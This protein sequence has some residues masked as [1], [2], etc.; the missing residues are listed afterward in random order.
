METIIQLRRPD[1][2]KPLALNLIL[3]FSQQFCGIATIT[4]YAVT[5][6]SDAGTAFDKYTAT[7]IFGLVRLVGT[8][9]GSSLLRSVMQMR[10]INEKWV[11]QRWAFDICD[12]M[13]NDSKLQQDQC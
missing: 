10:V 9:I 4:Y 5:I 3:M 2:W 13:V 12:S 8:F 7:I 11:A 6:M 1:V